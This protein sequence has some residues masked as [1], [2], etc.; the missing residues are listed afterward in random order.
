MHGSRC[1]ISSKNLVSQRCAEGFN[2]GVKGLRKDTLFLYIWGVFGDIDYNGGLLQWLWNWWS[3][4]YLC[5]VTCE[6]LRVGDF[7]KFSMWDAGDWK[8]FQEHGLQWRQSMYVEY[9]DTILRWVSKTRLGEVVINS[10]WTQLGFFLEWPEK[11]F[12]RVS[13]T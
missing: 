9:A 8:C 3:W 4:N 7:L 12:V 6:C 5:D 2:S 13:A 11:F 1:K 10:C